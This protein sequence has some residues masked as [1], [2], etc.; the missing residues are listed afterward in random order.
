MFIGVSYL[1]YTIIRS[2]MNIIA[3]LLYVSYQS[4]FALLS[5][6]NYRLILFFL[7]PGLKIPPQSGH[8]HTMLLNDCVRF[9]LRVDHGTTICPNLFHLLCSNKYPPKCCLCPQLLNENIL[10]IEKTGDLPA[11]FSD[12][13]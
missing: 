8:K 5:K 10:Q 2:I 4:K 1:S 12:T 11:E 7:V 3:N 6:I 13:R 9:W